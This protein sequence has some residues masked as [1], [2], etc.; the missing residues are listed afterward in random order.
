MINLYAALLGRPPHPDGMGEGDGQLMHP[1]MGAHDQGAD[2]Q[3]LESGARR[4]ADVF[5][6]RLAE[7]VGEHLP[8]EALEALA[9]AGTLLSGVPVDPALPGTQTTAG[10][11]LD[12]EATADDEPAGDVPSTV[13][14]STVWRLQAALHAAAHGLSAPMTGDEAEQVIARLADEVTD[15]AALAGLVDAAGP[16]PAG[17][18][19]VQD[20]AVVGDAPAAGDTE[21]PESAGHGEGD[22][23]EVLAAPAV[24]TTVAGAAETEVED[25]TSLPLRGDRAGSREGGSRTETSLPGLRVGERATAT[26]VDEVDPD[27]TLEGDDAEAELRTAVRE[28]RTGASASG[29]SLSRVVRGERLGVEAPLTT[30]PTEATAT[31]R[32]EVSETGAMRP[33]AAA[34]TLERVLEAAARLD[35]MPPPRQLTLEVGE[36]RVRLGIEDGVLRVQLVGESQPEDRDLLRDVT[37][38]LRARGFDLGHGGGRGDGDGRQPEPGQQPAPPGRGATTGAGRPSAAM[39]TTATT[40]LRL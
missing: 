26:G 28:P 13:A 1:L 30:T 27:A 24:A 15:A 39:P 5:D 6:E 22:L 29:E 14:Q 33:S 9:D 31:P 37:A 35:R 25:E 23:V 2:E 16:A 18:V 36:A 32:S 19:G 7:A 38:E 17:G 20:E 21:D 4:F 34:A 8:P 12:G 3:R 10:L 11:V 40:D